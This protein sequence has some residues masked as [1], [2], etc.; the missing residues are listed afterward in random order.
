MPILRSAKLADGQEPGPGP[1]RFVPPDAPGLADAFL[2][3]QVRALG[4]YDFVVV[5]GSDVPWAG[6]EVAREEA[7]DLRVR[8]LP[9]DPA[10]LTEL[11]RGT[12]EQLGMHPVVERKA[13]TAWER[14]VSGD[15][16]TAVGVVDQILGEVFGRSL[17]GAL[18]VHHGS[19]RAEFEGA[20][21]ME[22]L[23]ARIEPILTELIG[24][25]PTRDPDGDWVFPYQSTQAFVAPRMMPDGMVVVRVF[26]IT[27]VGLT[28]TPQLAVFI[29]SLNFGL[30]FCRFALDVQ[31]GAVWVDETLLGDL[32]S[33]GELRFTIQTVASTAADWQGRIKETFDGFTGQDLLSG[34]LEGTVPKAKPGRGG[35]L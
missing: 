27:N 32:V 31:H 18:D 28:I 1:V 33:D 35:Y 26:A 23:R 25:M 14:S 16:G 3:E 22:A 17:Q 34:H 5:T 4:P 8:L 30:P 12:L 10:G 7:G 6:F 21:K 19:H 13:G 29:A 15:A 20:R 2:V 24:S 9:G 11:Q